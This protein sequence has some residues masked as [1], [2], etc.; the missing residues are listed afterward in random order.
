MLSRRSVHKKYQPAVSEPAI[1]A[2]EKM[3]K[4]GPTEAVVQVDAANVLS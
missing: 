4:E 2:M 1:D 3:F